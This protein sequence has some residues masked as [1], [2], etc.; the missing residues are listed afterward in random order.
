VIPGKD[1][2]AWKGFH[3]EVKL[4][5]DGLFLSID[6]ST[7]FLHEPTILD[8]INENLAD[9]YSREEIS[10]YLCPKVS[11]DCDSTMSSSKQSEIDKQRLVVVTNYNSRAY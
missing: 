11:D 1:L 2:M 8:I 3:C 9:G 5:N 10:E 6:T 7:K 4:L